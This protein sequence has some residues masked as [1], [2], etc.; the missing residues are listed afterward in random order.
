MRKF[1]IPLVSA[2]LLAF[3]CEKA[4]EEIAVTD[5]SIDQATAEM[6]IG[7]KKQ[8]SA[9][10]TPS[11]A[12]DQ[13]ISWSSS[14]KSVATVSDHGM[15]TAIAEGKTTIK[16][17]AGDKTSV[18]VVTVRKEVIAV[19]S[20]SLDKNSLSLVKG[21]SETLVAT[22]NPT[23]A[24]H[25]TVSWTSSDPGVATVD[26]QGSV[27]AIANGN[28]TITAQVDDIKATCA[29]SVTVP[30]ES[31]TLNKTRLTLKKGE[32]ETL[33][34]TILPADATE[35][36][37]TWNTTNSNMASVDANGKVTAV[38]GGNVTISAKVG[39]KSAACMVTVTV[40]VESV[41][42]NRT[43]ITLDEGQSAT[44]KATVTPKDATD[45]TVTWSSSD[46]SIVTV[47]QEGTINAI[48]QGSA[49]IQ[50]KA[51]DKLATCTVTVI[52]KVTSVVLDKV[53]LTLLVGETSTLTA[54]VLP[55]DATDK[56]VIWRS[57]DTSVATVENGVVK[58]IGI[59]ETT[60]TATS[61]GI[62]TY[63]SI[64]VTIDSAT[65]VF[66]KRFGGNYTIIEGIVQPG[67]ELDMGLVNLSS[68]TIHV[69][70][71]QLIDGKTGESD[72]EKSI[73]SD[74]PSC[75]SDFWTIS[76]SEHGIYLP[77]VRF[78]YSFKG[79]IYTC[80]TQ[81]DD[82]PIVAAP[83]HPAGK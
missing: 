50:A 71:L 48:K 72:Y 59:G 19:T 9:T 54:T 41:T 29:V 44:L 62:T 26:S 22:V 65:G 23:N 3:S 61:G 17:R 67:S 55:E 35:N 4:P 13:S 28:A 38:G 82:T 37:V 64:S 52:K 57:N 34:A 1:F 78:I 5:I 2:L 30:V 76:I 11:D 32:S 81:I 79:D 10:V 8:L 16:A 14:N 46:E 75:L 73:E 43:G 56:T 49:T 31:I 15:V 53:S 36:K 74:I 68:E 83:R 51:E 20:I 33:V 6:T 70:S 39:G 77:I 12:T 24:T 18:C 66:V 7:E 25:T 58:G 42:L 40:P 21:E 63:C 60:I 69:V 47:D 27:K 80:E 45:K